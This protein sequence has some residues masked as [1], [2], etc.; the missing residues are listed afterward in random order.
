MFKNADRKELKKIKKELSSI[1]N[2]LWN[3]NYLENKIKALEKEVKDLEEKKHSLKF[4]GGMFQGKVMIMR[5]PLREN[6][7]MLY[8]AMYG[9]GFIAGYKWTSD[10]AKADQYSFEEAYQIKNNFCAFNDN[11][12]N[13]LIVCVDDIKDDD[14]DPEGKYKNELLKKD[15]FA[16]DEDE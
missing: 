1:S 7:P 8:L 11:K 13:L 14:Y 10:V 5:T 9:D 12:E 16:K 15:G 2:E 6:T 3:K 4:T